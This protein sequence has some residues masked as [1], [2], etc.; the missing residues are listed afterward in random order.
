[1]LG[2]HD[3][4]SWTQII[5]AE[6][7]VELDPS[8][9]FGRGE[10]EQGTCSTVSEV[11]CFLTSILGWNDRGMRSESSHSAVL[12]VI[13]SVAGKCALRAGRPL[14]LSK[15]PSHRSGDKQRGEW[16]AV[17]GETLEAAYFI[18]L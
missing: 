3:L 10:L 2:F 8:C 18:E 9:I 5:S 12:G 16:N 15:T 1:M 6:F 7:G 17:Q 11:V 14:F 13:G 4:W